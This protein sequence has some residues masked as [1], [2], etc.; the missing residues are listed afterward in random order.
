MFA[1]SLK[2][3]AVKRTPRRA[4]RGSSASLRPR[5][6]HASRTAAPAGREERALKEREARGEIGARARVRE[7]QGRRAAR[8]CREARDAA[9]GALFPGGAH[10]AARG[11]SCRG[12][13][14]PSAPSGSAGAPRA[15]QERAQSAARAAE[16]LPSL[17]SD[18][19]V[20]AGGRARTRAW[21]GVRPFR[22]GSRALW[23]AER[24]GGRAPGPA[25]GR[26]ARLPRRNRSARGGRAPGPGF[27]W[28]VGARARTRMH[29]QAVQWEPVRLRLHSC[30]WY[31]R[32]RRGQQKEVQGRPSYS[33]MAWARSVTRA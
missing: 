1:S 27:G 2:Q 19:V 17:D 4:R 28:P 20:A 12:A 22:Q 7:Q 26:R 5:A 25:R 18:G 6:A 32:Q 10:G 8:R 13:G 29:A 24:L 33:V 31:S 3:M 16:G 14:R 30:C 11:R 23:R 15:R 9:V 21:G